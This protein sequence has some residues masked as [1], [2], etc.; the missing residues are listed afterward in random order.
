MREPSPRRVSTIFI[1]SI[2]AFCAS[3]TMTKALD[4]RAPAHEGERRH[5]DLPALAARLQIVLAHLAAER[6]PDRLQIGIDLLGEIARQIAELL[7]CLHGGPRD[8]D[9]VD[10]LL[11]QRFDRGGDGEEGL[12]GAGRADAEN[13]IDVLV[14]QRLD[15][16][17][18]A[19]RAQREAAELRQLSA[20]QA[21]RAAF[22]KRD[23]GQHFAFAH[24]AFAARDDR[25]AHRRCAA[26]RSKSA[27]G[28]AARTVRLIA[29]RVER[30]A[31][32]RARRAARP[33]RGTLPGC[34]RG[35]GAAGRTRLAPRRLRS[36]VMTRSRALPSL[37]R[38]P[39]SRSRRAPAS[40]FCDAAS[41]RTETMSP[42]CAVRVV[43][44]HGLQI[45]RAAVLLARHCGRRRSTRTGSTRPT[46]AALNARLLFA[47]ATLA[48]AASVRPFTSSAIC[49]SIAAAGVPGRGEYLNEN[50]EA[51][52][53]S[54]TSCSVASKSCLASR[55]ESRR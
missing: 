19:R 7:A 27:R 23:R 2:V 48:G 6:I 52:P 38:P 24:A 10:A 18:L 4:E 26:A 33:D 17:H 15:I 53:I 55:R 50:A 22:G 43:E 35:G 5:F 21:L 28:R 44:M 14:A 12:A 46:C 47:R 11:L 3:S 13:E 31:D 16:M 29:L 20:G 51:K 40:E 25:P 32:R 39:A 37:T 1:C 9:A 41:M 8:D 42:F 49:P 30:D 36:S 54:R 34:A 45:G